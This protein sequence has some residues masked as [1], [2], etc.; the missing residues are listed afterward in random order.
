LTLETFLVSG[1]TIME[2][3]N[4]VRG[5]HFLLGVLVNQE[6]DPSCRG[7]NAFKNTLAAAREGLAAFKASEADA[8]MQLSPEFSRLWDGTVRGFAGL[9]MPDQTVG[10]KKAGNCKLP[11]GLCFL[12]TS[13]AFIQRI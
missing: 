10:Q 12:K 5:Y 9:S 7:C 11:E 8:L 3:L 1:G 2:N 6:R 4:Q 13:L